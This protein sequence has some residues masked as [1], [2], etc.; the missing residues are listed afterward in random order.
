MVKYNIPVVECH[1]SI[2]ALS[3]EAVVAPFESYLPRL[4]QNNLY[5][6]YSKG[7][8][9]SHSSVEFSFGTNTKAYRVGK[10]PHSHI[11]M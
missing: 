7:L 6:C 5:N 4:K 9:F 8:T 11:I 2:A 10:N 1:S 3:N